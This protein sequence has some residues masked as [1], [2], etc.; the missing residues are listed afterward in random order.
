MRFH[1]FEYLI[2]LVA[3]LGACARLPRRPRNVVLLAASWIFYGWVHPWYVALIVASTLLDWGCALGIERRPRARR[4]LLLAS[5]AGNLGLLGAFKYHDFFA[6]ELAA[7]LAGAGLPVA[8]PLLELALPVGISFYTFQSMGYTIDVY[9]GV[10]HARRDPIDVALFVSFFPQLVAGPVERAGDLLPQLESGRRAT[11]A[12]R[13]SGLGLITWGFVKKLAIADHVALWADRIFELEHPAWPVLAAGALA[14]AVQILA[15]FSAYTDI[16]R[17]SARL[18]G[19][20]LSENFRAPYLASNPSDFWRRWHISFSSWIR[21]YVY[22]P[23]GGSRRGPARFVVAALGA[24]G[25]AGLWHGA[26]WTFVVWGL[27]HGALIVLWH[28]VG[29]AVARAARGVFGARPVRV[30]GIALMFPVTLAGWVLF[31]QG[32][33]ARLLDYVRSLAWP[34]DR[35]EWSVALG[36]AALVVG[37]ALPMM[38]AP[39]ARRALASPARAAWLRPVLVGCGWACVFLFGRESGSDFLYFRF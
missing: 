39:V 9:R 5:L 15:D 36:V 33:P 3:V 18:L 27:Y 1:S 24:M 17:G 30:A 21:D 13:A 26:A 14:F 4:A 19:I 20:E 2:F 22:I 7:A 38:L 31:R 10:T 16:A 25:L 12:Q 6:G 37:L 23:L 28:L 29:R 34:V 11:G 32:D 8:L 35:A